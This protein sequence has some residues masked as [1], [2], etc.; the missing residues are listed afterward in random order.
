MY[1]VLKVHEKTLAIYD[2]MEYNI[3][4]VSLDFRIQK[5]G[6][7]IC[8]NRII[9]LDSSMV[10]QRCGRTPKKKCRKQNSPR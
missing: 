1:A 8:A 9:I 10:E 6:L 7:Y 3:V 4:S 2:T 5:N